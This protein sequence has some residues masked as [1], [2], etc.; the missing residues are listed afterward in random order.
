[1]KSRQNPTATWR[2]YGGNLLAC[3]ATLCFLAELTEAG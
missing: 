3:R 2:H 1:M